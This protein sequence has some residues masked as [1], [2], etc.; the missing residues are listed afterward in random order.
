MAARVDLLIPA[1]RCA[2]HIAATLDSALAQT[3]RDQIVI[4]V[5]LDGRDA[6]SLDALAPYEARGDIRLIVN[7][8]PLGWARNCQALIDGSENEFFEI[9]FHDDALTP[10]AVERL[11]AALDARPDAVCAYG[12]VARV[13]PGADELIR[14]MESIEGERPARLLAAFARR[15]P[16][17]ALRGLT[18]DGS[19]RRAS[20]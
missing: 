1:Y 3:A 20:G 10:D 2:D 15:F 19:A 17:T 4:H 7:E 11:L 6:A 13:K 14:G 5:S 18:G 12:D 9:L 16:G 8:T